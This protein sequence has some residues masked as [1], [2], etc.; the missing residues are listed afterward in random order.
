MS[1]GASSAAPFP[2]AGPTLV[3]PWLS[4]L[5]PGPPKLVIPGSRS[6]SYLTMQH[7]VARLPGALP[8]SRLFPYLGGKR[9]R[10]TEGD[11]SGC[12]GVLL[13]Q[14]SLGRRHQAAT[15]VGAPGSSSSAA[16]RGGCLCY[17]LRHCGSAPC[18]SQHR[19]S[20]CH[21]RCGALPPGRSAR[22]RHTPARADTRA[23]INTR[24]HTHKH[25]PRAHS[26]TH[27]CRAFGGNLCT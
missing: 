9:N 13:V 27:E 1:S 3:L 14:P 21:S 4:K 17:P 8:P 2:I 23:P 16:G 18:P 22:P 26:H 7:L 25:V 10:E 5:L 11:R 20:S 6:L 15:R 19:K 24:V 12:P